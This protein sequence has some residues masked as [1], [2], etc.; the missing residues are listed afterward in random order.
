MLTT[1][2]Y[3]IDGKVNYALEGSVFVA[4]AVV[5]WLRDQLEMINDASEI[6]A[7]AQ[8]VENNGGVTFISALAGLGAPYWDPHATGSILGITRGTQKGHIARAALE[9]IA[10]RVRE[11]VIEMQKDANTT[12]KSLK[13]DGGASNNNLLMQTQADLIKADV[14]RPQTT[15]TTAIG[16]AFF[17]GLATGYWE[18]VESLVEIWSIDKKFLPNSNSTTQ[19][20]IDLWNKRIGKLTNHNTKNE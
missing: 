1:I 4:G 7:L 8:T 6:E 3:Q 17:A 15:E 5:Q 13:V 11:I 12:F 9:A 20:T 2:G 14:I 16:A 10:L 19:K 18:S